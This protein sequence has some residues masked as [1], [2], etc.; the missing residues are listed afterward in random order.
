VYE[1][2]RRLD[3]E[4][5]KELLKKYSQGRSWRLLKDMEGDMEYYI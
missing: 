3:A 5:L 4:E 2:K 1:F